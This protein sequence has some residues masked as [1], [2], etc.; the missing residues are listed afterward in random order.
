MSEPT[1]A[2][3]IKSKLNSVN[4]QLEEIYDKM[5]NF[6][7]DEVNEEGLD[8]YADFPLEISQYKV[9]KILFSTGGPADWIEIMIDDDGEIRKID[10]HY[11]NWFDHAQ[12]SVDKNTYLWQY[13]EEQVELQLANN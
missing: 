9:I 5:N 1:C 11:S 12:M 8:E 7:N 3:E 2:D 6:D 4:E 13:A 10:Y